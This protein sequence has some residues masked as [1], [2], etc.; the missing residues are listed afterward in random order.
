MEAKAAPLDLWTSI[1]GLKS[2]KEQTPE[3][4]AP[5]PRTGLGLWDC[6]EAYHSPM[7]YLYLADLR[8]SRFGTLHCLFHF[9]KSS[10][11]CPL[12][13]LRA[14]RRGKQTFYPKNFQS[15]RLY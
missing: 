5:Q 12:R 2:P 3:P 14:G 8:P 4:T 1:F 15:G 11:Q 9:A 6:E 13:T 10:S 7:L